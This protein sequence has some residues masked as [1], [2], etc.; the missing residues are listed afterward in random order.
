[1]A[2]RDRLAAWIGG[3]SRAAPAERSITEPI[4]G[5]GAQPPSSL[6]TLPPWGNQ[7][8]PIYAARYFGEN[9]PVVLACV[10]AIAGGI[11]SLPMGVYRRTA[12]GRQEAPNHPVARLLQ[13]PNELQ[14]G[15]DFFE[16]LIASALLSG[17]AVAVVDHDARGAPTGLYPIPWWACQPVLIPAAPAEMI[18]SPYVPNSKLVFDVTMTMMPWPLPGARPANG[19]PIRY[20]TD[21]VVFLRDRSDDGILGRSRLS[22]CPEALAAGLGAQG[23]SANV[24]ANGAM[25]G[26]V[27]KHPGRLGKE[28]ADNL[29]QSWRTTHSGPAG[30][31]KVA[32]LEEGMTFDKIGVSPEDAEL[33]DSRRFSVEELCRVFGV[34]PPI[35]GEWTHA[36]F[37]NTASAR[38][39]FAALTLLPWVNKVEREFSRV[40][41]NTEDVFLCVDMSGMLRGDFPQLVASYVNLV[42]TGIASADE[43]RD[44]V[45]LDPRGGDADR[46]VATATGGR[47]LGAADGAGDALPPVN[48]PG[49][50]NGS[51]TAGTA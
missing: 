41:L 2:W 6:S 39:W 51:A 47:P 23:F 1:M 48:G 37:S 27:L 15:A 25:V 45:G 40:V 34:P 20:N 22:R 8:P 38:E 24:W 3:P 12:S 18:G 35:I 5:S 30:A 9:L 43:A 32:V 17:N 50:T 49:L 31:G 28:A 26:G 42:R 19:Y 36:T 7:W 21:E 46:L 11:A 29:A 10:Q 13:R 4:G 16:W 44:A 14:T 33:L